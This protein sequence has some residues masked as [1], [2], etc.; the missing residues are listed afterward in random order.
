MVETSNNG[1]REQHRYGTPHL[2]NS[3]RAATEHKTHLNHF[4]LF[5]T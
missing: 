4:D 2:S 5:I 1:V 3:M